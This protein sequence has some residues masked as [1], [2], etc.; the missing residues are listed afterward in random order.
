MNAVLIFQ[1]LKDHNYLKESFH[2]RPPGGK[3]IK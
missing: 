2:P 3:M 1:M